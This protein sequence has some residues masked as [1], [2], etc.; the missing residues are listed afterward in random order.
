[1]RRYLFIKALLLICGF[2]GGW[3]LGDEYYMKMRRQG[4]WI[5]QGEGTLWDSVW[6]HRHIQ[7]VEAG[8]PSAWIWAA[9]KALSEEEAFQRLYFSYTGRG[10]GRIVARTQE[11]VARVSL[12]LRQYYLSADVKRLPFIKPLDLPIIEAPRWDS[13]AFGAILDFWARNPSYHQLTSRI[14]QG[15]DGLWRAYLEISPETFVLGRTEHLQTGFA[16]M[17]VYLRSLQPQIGGFTCKT[18]LLYIPDQIVCQ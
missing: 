12:P 1:M 8:T 6:A 16:Q 15:S 4:R 3:A 7:A 5:L 14:Q 11:P 9:Y 18:V 2:S 10:D 17:T 13:T